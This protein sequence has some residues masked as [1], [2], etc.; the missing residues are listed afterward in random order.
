MQES[1]KEEYNHVK[2]IHCNASVDLNH[3][4]VCGICNISVFAS[5]ED[6]SKQTE[7][8]E[9]ITGFKTLR[10]REAYDLGRKH[11]EET[12]S[13]YIRDWQGSTG[14]IIGHILYHKFKDLKHL[15]NEK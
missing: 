9:L 1:L 2:C 15:F 12:L 8:H 4:D 13:N 7:Q 10:E 5:K 14:S 6:V 11:E 3:T